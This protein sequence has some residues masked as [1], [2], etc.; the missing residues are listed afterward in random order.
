MGY[1]GFGL[2][3]WVY[4]QRPRKFFSK[5][6]KPVAD[7]IPKHETRSVYSSDSPQLIGRLKEQ[8]SE[9]EI[10]EKEFVR[11]TNKIYRII[12]YCAVLF[13][14][15][16]IAVNYHKSKDSRQKAAQARLEM[17]KERKRQEIANSLQ[18][19]YDY[20]QNYIQNQDYKRAVNEFRSLVDVAPNDTRALDAYANALYLNCLNDSMNCDQALIQYQ[21][22]IKH[23]PTNKYQQ[24]LS[25]IYIHLGLYEK[26]DSVLN[27][28]QD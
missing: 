11:R 4:K 23:R 1:M 24:R 15:I 20:G 19:R 21:R 22:L 10:K 26:A 12:I 27:A 6:R 8:Q 13:L 7:T 25:E 3:K 5:E 2:N 17:L 16:Y 9:E 18:M 14:V 28:L